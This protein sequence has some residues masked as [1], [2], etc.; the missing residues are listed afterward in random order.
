MKSLTS[1]TSVL[2]KM[3]MNTVNHEPVL[4]ILCVS[5]AKNFLFLN[6]LSHYLH[7]IANAVQVFYKWL[8][9]VHGFWIQKN[10]FQMLPDFQICLNEI[11]CCWWNFKSFLLRSF[12]E[13]ITFYSLGNNSN[14]GQ[15]WVNNLTKSKFVCVIIIL[16]FS[17]TFIFFIIEFNLF[18]SSSDALI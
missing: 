18:K 13:Q 1:L 9:L 10:V 5:Q 8:E 6:L 14:F 11:G 4:K 7:N 15:G 2:L 3:N 17:K 16:L 12:D